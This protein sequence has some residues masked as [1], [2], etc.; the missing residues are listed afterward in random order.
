MKEG[1]FF[2][3]PSSIVLSLGGSMFSKSASSPARPAGARVRTRSSFLSLA[4]EEWRVLQTLRPNVLL[5]GTTEI[6]EQA[7]QCLQS[8]F[9]RPLR[10]WQ[11]GRAL[12]LPATG[13]ALGTLLVKEPA[14]MSPGE[15]QHLADWLEGSGRGTQ[16]A[17]TS[18]DPLLPQVERGAFHDSL[19]YRLNVVLL[20][21]TRAAADRRLE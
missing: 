19:Y 4:P 9:R 21:L 11:P 7:L 1:P 20:D 6:T 18:A 10:A 15:Q 8:T 16:I 17:T 5:L 13:A 14:L 2:L 3:Q 12:V